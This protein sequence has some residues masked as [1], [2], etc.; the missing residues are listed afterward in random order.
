MVRDRLNPG[1]EVLLDN[2][3]PTLSPDRLEVGARAG[4]QRLHGVWL[5]VVLLFAV[6][7]LVAY[8]PPDINDF[9]TSHYLFSYAAGF[10]K[11]ALLGSLLGLYFDRL[12]AAT[13]YG[14]SLCTL[15]L[16]VVALLLFLRRALLTSSTML[17]LGVVLL[18]APAVLPHFAYAI[19]YFDP[20]LV[21]CA[22]LALG[23]LA[24]PLPDWLKVPIAFLPCAFGVLTHE[25]FAL[26]AF[27]LVAGYSLIARTARRKLIWSLTMA[28]L[29]LTVVVQVVGHPTIGLDEY[30]RMA[31]ARTDMQI[32]AEAFELL[33]FQPREN[34]YY[35]VRH[36]SSIATDVRL[37]AGLIVPIPYF[38]MLRDLYT[39]A[40]G[41][42]AM[43]AGTRL[44]VCICVFA[45]VV[46]AL[47]G[48]DVL[49]WVSFVCL[50]CSILIC[51]CVRSDGSGAVVEAVSRYVR[52]PRFVLLALLS[53]SLGAL[54]VVDSNSLGSGVH[55]MAR[56][57]GLVQW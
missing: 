23:V 36:Y 33:Y 3:N 30:M 41:A 11:R 27:P 57:L 55:A 50:N 52:S 34:L 49:R 22:L 16:L 39:R 44:V 10:H 18:G 54:H 13:L 47:V 8:L 32:N 14:I 38:V 56:G 5:C 40:A 7:R 46:L 1:T 17:I 42:S 20:V 45:P 53:F 48:F 24:G 6:C 43:T 28:V 51:E 37:L 35:L 29:A 15:A 31:A 12:G 25:S 19:G 9:A 26:A 21:I 2:D 4:E